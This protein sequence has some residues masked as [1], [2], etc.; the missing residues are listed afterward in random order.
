MIAA[1]FDQKCDAGQAVDQH[2]QDGGTLILSEEDKEK[3]K[4]SMKGKKMSHVEKFQ[5]IL[6]YQFEFGYDLAINPKLNVS[7]S[8]GFE[9]FLGVFGGEE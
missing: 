5:A 3:I 6:A 8:P 9:S 7:K 1:G 4:S 2:H